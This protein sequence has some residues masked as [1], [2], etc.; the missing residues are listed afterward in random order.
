MEI[1]GGD[2]CGK[3]NRIDNIDQTKHIVG[4]VR[5]PWDWYV[6]LWAYGCK[7]LGAIYGRTTKR[8]DSDYY[9]TGLKREM[10]LKRMPLNAA[11]ITLIHD[12]YKPTRLWRYL[13]SDPDNPEL[14]KKW[15]RI[16]LSKKG[17]HDIGE[18]YAFC[19]ISKHSGLLTY[20]YMKLYSDSIA[21]FYDRTSELE[22][23]SAMCDF[24]KKHNMLKSIIRTENLEDDLIDAIRSGGYQLDSE[25]TRHINSA[26]LNKANTSLHHGRSYYY[27]EETI[28]LVRSREK[29]II[30]KHGYTC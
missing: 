24:D 1:V 2:L 15:I 9:I 25:Q 29:L 27:D 14:F 4:S 19:P 20:R 17:C 8:F 30:E 18:G 3:H 7:Q 22:T 13:Y 6:S 26:K 12:M 21:S 11:A 16:V 5:N 28:E 23:Y 10:S